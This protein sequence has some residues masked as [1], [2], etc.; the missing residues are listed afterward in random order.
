[1]SWPCCCHRI[2]SFHF[3]KCWARGEVVGHRCGFQFV[4]DPCGAHPL[5]FPH[6]SSAEIRPQRSGSPDREGCNPC[7]TSSVSLRECVLISKEPQP[8]GT[9]RPGL[10]PGPHP[11][12]SRRTPC[13]GAA[14]PWLPPA[15]GCWLLVAPCS[16][17]S[18]WGMLSCLIVLLT[19][20]CQGL[21]LC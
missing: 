8:A 16:T 2:A 5:C 19:F 14:L 3:S 17:V 10:E 11:P 13:L 21:L 6:A 20:A 4:L 7:A 9:P 12:G 1:M 18:S 15:H